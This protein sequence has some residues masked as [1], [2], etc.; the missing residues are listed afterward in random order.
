[1]KGWY[2]LVASLATNVFILIVLSVA[3]NFLPDSPFVSYTSG[4]IFD[5]FKDYL[6]YI[7]WFLPISQIIAVLELWVGCVLQYFLWEF[8]FK[9][10]SGVSGSG[11]SGGLTKA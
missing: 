9:I 6:P 11:A 2:T 3:C 4:S 10:M 7:N 8:L 1:M 5:A